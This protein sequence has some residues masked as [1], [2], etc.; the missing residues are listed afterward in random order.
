MRR[1]PTV[2]GGRR[3]WMAVESFAE[4]CEVVRCIDVEERWKLV[5]RK[6]VL[7]QTLKCFR[8][9]IGGAPGKTTE[10]MRRAA[11]ETKQVEAAVRAGAENGVVSLKRGEGEL[12]MMLS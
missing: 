2:C 6:F 12:Q 5:D 8:R 11:I 10:Q 4:N 7:A 3:E 1:I 9:G